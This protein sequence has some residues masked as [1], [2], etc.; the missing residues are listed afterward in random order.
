VIYPFFVFFFLFWNRERPCRRCRRLGDDCGD[1]QHRKRGRAAANRNGQPSVTDHHDNAGCLPHCGHSDQPQQ[2]SQPH[3]Q[4][5]DLLGFDLSA[6]ASHDLHPLH[7]EAT[8]TTTATS[9]AQHHAQ[10]AGQ[11]GDRAV[12]YSYDHHQQQQELQEQRIASLENRLEVLTRLVHTMG[13]ELRELHQANARLRAKL[14]RRKVGAKSSSSDRR[15]APEP[16]GTASAAA[17]TATIWPVTSSSSPS[18]SSSSPPLS[19]SS[20]STSPS[21]SS[22]PSSSSSHPFI[23]ER[24]PSFAFE[25][26][27][28]HSG[29]SPVLAM[30]ARRQLPWLLHY[31]IPPRFSIVDFRCAALPL[32]QEC[33][34]VVM[35]WRCVLR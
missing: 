24:R 8:T 16:S 15:P 28:L 27:V 12:H 10:H 2:P 19:S 11:V 35:T 21:T 13:N 29:V 7:D 30:E 26:S 5:E 23:V 22:S 31:D 32:V 33:G 20:S 9:T 25:L 18:S 17:F 6:T 3:L 14:K 4:L 1:Q 34:L